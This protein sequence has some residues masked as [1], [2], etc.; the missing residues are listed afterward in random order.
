VEVPSAPGADEA[1]LAEGRE[2]YEKIE[3]NKCH[4]EAGRGDGPSAPTLEDDDDLPVRAADLTEN[5]FFNGGG[6]VEE[7]HERLVTGLNG[8][9]MP[10]FQDLIAAEFMTEEQLG[11]WRSTYAAWRRRS[12]RSYARWSAP[13][14]WRATCRRRWTTRRG[15]WPSGSTC[16]SSGR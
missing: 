16:R 10:S 9:P 2:F 14:A 5:W 13:G 6:S 7:I 4:G 11:T 3:C 1:A 8:T 12:R 15:T